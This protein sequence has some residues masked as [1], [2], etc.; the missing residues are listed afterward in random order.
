M[1]GCSSP[2]AWSHWRGLS[3]KVISHVAA[4]LFHARRAIIM[5]GRVPGAPSSSVHPRRWKGGK[6]TPALHVVVS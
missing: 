3:K 4:V 5:D 2:P 6:P 1:A